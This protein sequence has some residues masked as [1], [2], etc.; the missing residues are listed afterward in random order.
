R[1]ADLVREDLCGGMLGPARLA[2]LDEAQPRAV[3]A[4]GELLRASVRSEY[5]VVGARVLGLGDAVEDERH[6]DRVGRSQPA[7]ECRRTPREAVSEGG[8]ITAR[9]VAFAQR[10]GRAV[11]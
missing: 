5:A 9:G 8:A 4:V 2:A 7:A 3:D 6:V 1:G 11:E 10:P